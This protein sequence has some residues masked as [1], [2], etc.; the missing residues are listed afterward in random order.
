[1]KKYGSPKKGF[2]YLK[3]NRTQ[4]KTAIPKYS[5]KNPARYKKK[6]NLYNSGGLF[7]DPFTG[8]PDKI[9]QDLEGGG[10]GYSGPARNVLTRMSQSPNALEE[11]YR[12]VTEKAET[13]E[14]IKSLIQRIKAAKGAI[15]DVLKKAKDALASYKADGYLKFNNHLRENG[16]FPV[17]DRY[18]EMYGG[19]RKLAEPLKEDMTVYRTVSLPVPIKTRKYTK[20][21]SYL[22]DE[23]VK[24][25]YNLAPGDTIASRGFTSSTTNIPTSKTGPMFKIQLYKGDPVIMVNKH[26][27]ESFGQKFRDENEIII[28]NNRRYMVSGKDGD[29]TEIKHFEKP[30]SEIR[31]PPQGYISGLLPLGLANMTDTIYNSQPKSVKSKDF[32]DKKRRIR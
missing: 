3:Y 8:T 5:P 21:G 25:L 32:T 2:N 31:I 4:G 20:D 30:H 16:G 15:P 27:P 10:G 13:P 28:P 7:T 29:F 11:M 26:L 18:S 19:L 14:A 12:L 23:P 24:D 9:I 1:M 22:Q 17:D 6:I